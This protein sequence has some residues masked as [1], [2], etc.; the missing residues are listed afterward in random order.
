MFL[1]YREL[2]LHLDFDINTSRQR[3]IHQ[4]IDRLRGWLGDIDEPLVRPHLESLMAI[5]EDMRATNDSRGV[6]VGWQG[7]WASHFR[8][9]PDSSIDD[10]L[11]RLVNHFIVISFEADADALGGFFYHESVV[12]SLRDLTY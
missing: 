2:Q 11:G 1:S 7:Y 5:L 10:L 9:S 3:E 12:I 6:S 4:R 8:A